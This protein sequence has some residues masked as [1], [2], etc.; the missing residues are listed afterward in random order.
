[1][2]QLET[3]LNNYLEFCE[4]QKRLDAKT[5]K[6]YRIDLNQFLGQITVQSI[7]E[8]LPDTLEKF[9][10]TLH[11]SYMPKT[12]KRKIA[13]VKAF[14]HYL[15]YKDY[16]YINPFNKIQIKF[17]EP[18]TLPKTIP[19]HTVETFLATMYQQYKTV[20]ST[21]QKRN[22]LRDIAIIELL[23]ATGMRISELCSL[24]PDKI[25]LDNK[26]I[27]IYGKGS[28]ERRI[29]IGNQDV[30]NLLKKYYKEYQNEILNCNRG[31]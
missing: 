5:L 9:I 8:I 7:E 23:F 22:T 15:Q 30:C 19:L 1:M 10:A 6:A 20:K 4:Q 29:Q 24:K 31:V 16:I 14:F 13:S 25:D 18:A 17:R 3:V 12:V 11:Q 26:S 28:K 21:Y 2:N 27:L